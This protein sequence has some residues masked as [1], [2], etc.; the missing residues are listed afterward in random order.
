MVAQACHESPHAAVAQ[1]V[2]LTDAW[3]S[4]APASPVDS[5][6]VEVVCSLVET[7]EGAVAVIVGD[8]VDSGILASK[9]SIKSDHVLYQFPLPRAAAPAFLAAHHRGSP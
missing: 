8:V 1:V 4:L 3:C 2:D 5:P 6:M 7:A 9:A